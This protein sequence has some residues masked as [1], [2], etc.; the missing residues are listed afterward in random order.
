MSKPRNYDYTAAQRVAKARALAAYRIDVTL[1]AKHNAAL[2]WLIEEMDLKPSA[3]VRR[4][5]REEAA[6]RGAPIE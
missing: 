1:D 3:I 5:L 4:L 6:R 2:E